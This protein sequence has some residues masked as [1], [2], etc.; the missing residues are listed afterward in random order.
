MRWWISRIKDMICARRAW[1]VTFSAIDEQSHN[2]DVTTEF[3]I[4]GLISG[5]WIG[6]LE[7]QNFLCEDFDVIP[8]IYHSE[9]RNKLVQ[10][11]FSNWARTKRPPRN[12]SARRLYRK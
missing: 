7:V 6:E 5:K 9:R 11:I 12:E 10:F 8:V 3:I 4:R 2:A 1:L